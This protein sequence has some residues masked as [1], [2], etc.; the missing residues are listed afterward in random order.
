MTWGTLQSHFKPTISYWHSDSS[1]FCYSC[2][3]SI[4]PQPPCP[5][6]HNAVSNWYTVMAQSQSQDMETIFGGIIG[7][8]IAFFRS[9]I[10]ELA[11]RFH[12]LLLLLLSSLGVV[13][14]DEWC[15]DRNRQAHIQLLQTTV[16]GNYLT[17]HTLFSNTL[18]GTS[19]LK[20]CSVWAPFCR[21]TLVKTLK[22]S[23]SGC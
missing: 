22:S 15:C 6:T 5:I 4:K 18:K 20:S 14:F 7:C 10:V 21:L 23:G 11:L 8:S 12:L 9:H 13:E 16:S 3:C 17:V 1:C 19:Q 2:S